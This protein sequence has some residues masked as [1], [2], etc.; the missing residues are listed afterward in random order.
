MTE[1]DAALEAWARWGRDNSLGW[2]TWTL[3]A[4]V[5]EQGYTGAA[6]KGPVP[7]MGETIW[8]VE[9]A[10]L[11][12]KPV[13]RTVVVKY[14]IHWQPVEVCAK[15]CHM[16]PNRFRTVLNRARNLISEW[17]SQAFGGSSKRH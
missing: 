12:L 13:E 17:V 1:V 3:L 5:A 2:P 9:Q 10:V 7:E 14:Y 11:R 8:A 16:S 4:K 15:H 6:Q